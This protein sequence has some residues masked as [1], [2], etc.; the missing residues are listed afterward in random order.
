[1]LSWTL[2]G[3][4]IFAI[5]ENNEIANPYFDIVGKPR[6]L[7]P[8]RNDI[9]T[10][11]REK[12]SLRAVPYHWDANNSRKGDPTNAF[13]N[14]EGGQKAK[15]AADVF[16]ATEGNKQYAIAPISKVLNTNIQKNGPPFYPNTSGKI[17]GYVNVGLIDEKTGEYKKRMFKNETNKNATYPAP[18]DILVAMTDVNLRTGPRKWD[19]TQKDYANATTVKRQGQGQLI[20][21]G[22]RVKVGGDIVLATG[23]L[24]IWAPISKF[25][26]TSE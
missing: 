26:S 2:A 20:K 1:M 6:A 17:R 15:V 16:I 5:I 14:I 23:G 4:A 24:S 11:N 10:P 25:L 8:T 9:I 18:N 22:Q 19:A 21:Q 3:N 12:V 7:L 13:A